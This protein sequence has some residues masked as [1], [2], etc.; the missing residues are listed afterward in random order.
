M[1]VLRAV[2]TPTAS[3]QTGVAGDGVSLADCVLG[4]W[5]MLSHL[6]L[7]YAN[8]VSCFVC[9]YEFIWKKLNQW[10]ASI[11]IESCVKYLSN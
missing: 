3:L 11:L 2:G 7:L 5:R 6:V 4:V 10:A 9:F 8:L 1:L